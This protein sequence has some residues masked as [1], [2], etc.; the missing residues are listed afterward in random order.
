M[1]STSSARLGR[2]SVLIGG[3]GVAMAAPWG[4]DATRP[5]KLFPIPR[6]VMTLAV[7]ADRLCW[8]TGP[9]HGKL[10]V[11]ERDDGP[12][13][14][15][16]RNLEWARDLVLFGDHAYLALATGVARA[17]LHGGPLLELASQAN[18]VQR[19]AVDSSGVFWIE[20]QTNALW[21]LAHDGGEA[22]QLT[23]GSH[24]A[25]AIALDEHHVYWTAGESG[26]LQRVP[27]AGGEVTVLHRADH[28]LT[29]LVC[30]REQLYWCTPTSVMALSLAGDRPQ[31]L[32]VDQTSPTALV[33]S[34]SALCWVNGQAQDQAGSAD[35]VARVKGGSAAP[36]PLQRGTIPQALALAD[37]TLY[38]ADHGS[39]GIMRA[40]VST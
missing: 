37:N 27:K 24:W 38:W 29:A 7:D 22:R 26:L 1:A 8:V 3:L 21:S 6:G 20:R 10:F 23:E 4:C 28:P 16:Q 2:R 31:A 13:L 12:A 18:G 39:R 40:S 25:N 36:R 19:L 5:K 17:S 14:P 11:A 33:V 15:Q 9:E 34:R 30:D 35:V 32:A